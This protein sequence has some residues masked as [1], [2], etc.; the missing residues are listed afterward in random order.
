M[1]SK[2]EFLPTSSRKSV[3]RRVSDSKVKFLPGQNLRYCGKG[4]AGFIKGQPYMVFIAY[5]R[6]HD[7]LVGY[8]GAN[9]I[10]NRYHI[11]PVG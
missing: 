4:F 9:V 8:N 3:A 7:A 11:D 10:V 5:Y 1:S 2:S 6:E